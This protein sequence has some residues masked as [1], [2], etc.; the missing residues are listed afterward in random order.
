MIL[1]KIKISN[2]YRSSIRPNQKSY[3]RFLNELKDLFNQIYGNESCRIINT[4][5]NYPYLLFDCKLY[6]ISISNL[7]LFLVLELNLPDKDELKSIGI[8]TKQ[9]LVF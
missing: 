8:N 5:I 6:F 7:F 1:F 2:E 4:D 3:N 9:R